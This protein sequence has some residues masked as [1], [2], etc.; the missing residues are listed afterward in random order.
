MDSDTARRFKLIETRL[1]RLEPKSSGL[2]AVRGGTTYTPTYLGA[3]TAGVTTYTTQKGFYAQISNVVWFTGRVTW[4]AATG[5]GIALI[6][7]PFTTQNTTD[8]RYTVALWSSGLTFANNNVI[9]FL[10]PGAS[11]FQMTSLLTNAAPTAVN[12]EAAG[13]VIFSGFF[14]V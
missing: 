12:V 3:T 6:S 8:L 1:G 4:T 2:S 11:Q 5:T 10:T 13:D 7:V 9:G 14:F